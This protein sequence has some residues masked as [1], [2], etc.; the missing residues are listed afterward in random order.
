M[1]PGCA[2]PA[3]M[4]QLLGIE[5]PQYLVGDVQWKERERITAARG[6]EVMK[7]PTVRG[8]GG[9]LRGNVVQLYSTQLGKKGS[10]HS[11]QVSLRACCRPLPEQ[12]KSPPEFS[13]RHSRTASFTPN[14]LFI[15]AGSFFDPVMGG[16]GT[17]G[18]ASRSQIHILFYLSLFIYLK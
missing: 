17:I 11:C 6:A 4:G 9:Q 2:H 18:A 1:L 7:T 13:R 10:H 3:C 16:Q 5:Q 15:S 8:G 14:L 12:S